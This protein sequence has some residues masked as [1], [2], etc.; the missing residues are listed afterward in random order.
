MSPANPAGVAARGHPDLLLESLRG[1]PLV[2]PLCHGELDVAGDAYRCPPCAR[3]FPLQG[4][5][6]DFRV[7]PDPYLSPEEDR[8]RTDV[9]LDKLH[10]YRLERLLEYYWSFSDI[11]PPVLRAQFVRSG[12]L[13]EDRAR[14][15]LRVLGDGTFR[16]PVTARRVLEVGSGTGNFLAEA[17]RHYPQV[18]G[19][20]IGMRWLHLSR[21]RFLDRG[22]PA[23][24]DIPAA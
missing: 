24:P 17:V 21:R 8:R 11:T 15:S 13:G 12:M 20:D 10:E 3:T 16:R 23:P 4:G 1:L 5:I 19:V 18:V 6:P 22:L 2:C 14:R 7:F 9:V